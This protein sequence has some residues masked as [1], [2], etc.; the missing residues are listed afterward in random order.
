VGP[1]VVGGRVL[2]QITPHMRILVAIESIDGRKGIDSIA[3]L[4]IV[5]KRLFLS[6]VR[7]GHGGLMELEPEVLEVS[8]G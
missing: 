4:S 6:I 1:G 3:L 7:E 5:K 2:I 8:L